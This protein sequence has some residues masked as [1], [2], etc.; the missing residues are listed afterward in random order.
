[1]EQQLDQHDDLDPSGAMGDRATASKSDKQ[2]NSQ[3]LG[4]TWSAGNIVLYVC[5]CLGINVFVSVFMSLYRY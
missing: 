2:T 5:I 1:M 4:G 3:R